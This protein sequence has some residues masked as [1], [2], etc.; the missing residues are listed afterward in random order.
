MDTI[1][2]NPRLIGI[3]CGLISGLAVFFISGWII[4]RREG[5][6]VRKRAQTANSEILHSL[7]H[8][9]PEKELPPPGVIESMLSSSARRHAVNWEELA[10][11]KHLA[12]E[13]ITEIMSNPFLSSHQKSEYCQIALRMAQAEPEEV[14]L[15]ES[16]SRTDEQGPFKGKDRR[17]TSIILGAAT[18][19]SVLRH[20]EQQSRYAHRCV[21]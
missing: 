20:L 3:V 19:S 6:E 5:K 9:L 18:F 10:G 1:V 8:L 15:G 13:I 7:R 17:D 14:N 4:S 16:L 21:Q 2:N 12:D 11:A